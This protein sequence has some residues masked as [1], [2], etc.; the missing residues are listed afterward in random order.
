MNAADEDPD[1]DSVAFEF[2]FRFPGQYFDKETNTHYNYFRDYDP[3]IGRYVQSDP[4]GL[5]GGLNTF[6]YVGGRPI[7]AIDPHGLLFDIMWGKVKEFIVENIAEI[8]G[9]EASK[10]KPKGIEI[11]KAVCKATNGKVASTRDQCMTG[12]GFPRVEGCASLTQGG[13]QAISSCV[14]ACQEEIKKCN[15]QCPID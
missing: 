15:P 14:T 8:V 3:A 5:L 13:P 11:G 4:I 7:D 2:N 9:S 6:A 10:A 12:V 1:N